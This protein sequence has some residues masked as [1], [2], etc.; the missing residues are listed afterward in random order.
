MAVG[1]DADLARPA[2]L[3]REA[4]A[5]FGAWAEAAA[6]APQLWAPAAVNL[7]AH[8]AA[9]LGADAHARHSPD[10]F[11]RLN[12]GSSVADAVAGC[13]R[14]AYAAGVMAS[15]A[16]VGGARPVAGGAGS[17]KD[18]S[19]TA[20]TGNWF[21]GAADAA[22]LACAALPKMLHVSTLGSR[23]W[24]RLHYSICVSG[25]LNR[26]PLRAKAYPAMAFT[27]VYI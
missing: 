9:A 24:L 3:P 16:G 23:L 20:G 7:L 5:W 18:E 2:W 19:S 15:Q 4:E 12:A 22:M 1:D 25:M 13:G 10:H 17:C 6:A 11:G 27:Q 8:L 14:Y 26:K 21:L